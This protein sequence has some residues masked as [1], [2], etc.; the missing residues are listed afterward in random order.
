MDLAV[1]LRTA[2]PAPAASPGRG[3]ESR[4]SLALGKSSSFI[5]ELSKA[6]VPRTIC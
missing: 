6:A 4:M 2:S 1:G 5:G 3:P